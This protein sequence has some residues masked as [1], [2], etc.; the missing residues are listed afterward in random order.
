MP[1]AV[2]LRLL[3]LSRDFGLIN[4]VCDT[5]QP[6]RIFC[7][8]C[9]DGQSA[10]KRLCKSK[11]EGILIDYKGEPDTAHVVSAVHSSTSHRMAITFGVVE[12]SQRA[13]ASRAGLHFV[14][15][16][17][18]DSK[19]LRRTL[20]AAFP[21]L[22]QEHR[23]YYRAPIAVTVTLRS[24]SSGCVTATSLNVSEGG[25][26]LGGAVGLVVGEKVSVEFQLPGL[27]QPTSLNAEVCWTK[28]KLAGLQFQRVPAEMLQDLK[29][30]LA[31]RLEEGIPELNRT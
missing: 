19:N 6:L 14:L 26:A 4:D 1:Y 12:S 18:L 21:L 31:E 29:S 10:L 3:L 28:E 5:A 13:E 7:E 16:R 30:W 9:S 24:G 20:R 11:F 2:P 15:S 22:V 27:K 23:R 8:I 17:P 25:M